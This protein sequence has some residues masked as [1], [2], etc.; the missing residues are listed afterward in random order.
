MY[1]TADHVISTGYYSTAEQLLLDRD[2]S[3]QMEG[4]VSLQVEDRAPEHDL[5]VL[6]S[7]FG[8]QSRFSE[9]HPWTIAQGWT[10]V[11]VGDA[12]A[13]IAIDHWDNGT[14]RTRTELGRIIS[15]ERFSRSGLHIGVSSQ[16]IQGN[17]GGIVINTSCDVVGLVV[18]IS[19]DLF[20]KLQGQETWALH[21]IEIRR[22]LEDWGVLDR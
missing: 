21:A 15:I 8:S 10:D 13:L 12:V 7:R 2:L 18:Q 6:T 3:R 4:A 11:N 22:F 19:E 16:A 17:S 5:A 1:V 14:H 9:M 20:R